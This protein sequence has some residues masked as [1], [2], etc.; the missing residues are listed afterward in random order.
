VASK[1][2][3]TIDHDEIRRWAEDHDGRAGHG[4]AEQAGFRS[5]WIS[6]HFQPWIDRQEGFFRFYDRELRHR[7]AG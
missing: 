6:D 2:R 3:T 4:R 7:L 1:S 5:V